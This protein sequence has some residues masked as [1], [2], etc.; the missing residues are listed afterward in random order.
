MTAITTIFGVLPMALPVLLPQFFP[1]AQGRAQMWAPISV[2]I[3][4]GLSTSTFFT[5]IILPTFYSIA[6]SATTRVKKFFK[7]ESH[8]PSF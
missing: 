7:F 3:L 2:A 6:D 1:A 4:G 5:L 8:N